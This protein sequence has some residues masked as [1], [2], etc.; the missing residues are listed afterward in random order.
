VH[1]VNELIA[2]GYFEDPKNFEGVTVGIIL[3]NPLAYLRRKRFVDQNLVLSLSLSLSLPFALFRFT[4][5][6]DY[7]RQSPYLRRKRFVDQMPSLSLF[8][9]YNTPPLSFPLLLHVRRDMLK[10]ET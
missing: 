7:P 8:L 10:T 5:C 1:A 2:E 6:H 4:L 9:S 3:G